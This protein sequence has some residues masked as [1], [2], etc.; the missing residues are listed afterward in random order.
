MTLFTAELKNQPGEFAHVAECLARAGV[1]VMLAGSGVGDIGS[2]VFS[3]DDET[4]A[5][6]ALEAAGIA[7]HEHSAIQVRFSNQ[8]GTAAAVARQLADANINI[9]AFLPV[10]VSADEA[11]GV[12]A[13]DDVEAARGLLG[14]RVL[15]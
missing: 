4:A 5:R 8:P 11:I 9:T 12:I 15:S 7:V 13:V 3:V 6:T 10:R 2:I 14:D 1:N